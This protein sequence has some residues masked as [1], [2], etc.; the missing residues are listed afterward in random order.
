MNK[1]MLGLIMW[2]LIPGAAAQ[3]YYGPG[4][5]GDALS[6]DQV[7]TIDVDYRFR[8]S[9]SSAPTSLLWYDEAQINSCPPPSGN[10]Y[11]CGTGGIM[12]ISIQTDDATTNHLASG[13][14]LCFGTDSSPLNPP[15]LRS[16]ALSSCP[17]LTAGTLYHIH[18]HNTAADPVNNFTSV[19]DE[20]VLDATIPRQPTIPDTDLAVFRGTTLQPKET[21]IFQLTYANGVKQGQGYMENWLANAPFISG[22]QTV[23]EQFTVSGG[24]KIVSSVSLRMKRD[25]SNTGTDPLTVTL[26]TGAGAL[27]EQGTI[28]ASTFPVGSRTGAGDHNAWGTY[29]FTTPRTLTNGQAYHLVLSAPSNTVFAMQSIRRG[30]SHG[31]VSPT[32]FGDG[33]GQY[34]TNGGSTW[35]GFDQPGGST[36][37]TNADMQFYFTIQ[38]GGTSSNPPVPPSGLTATVR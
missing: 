25:T 8:A 20:F 6:N 23:R 5:G 19:D 12:H 13:T 33:Y 1:R 30:P 36:N 38:T 15:A 37:N 16:Q 11:G 18:W 17:A 4:I 31:F 35:S 26:E 32:F 34:S 29:T 24:D 21:P 2:L 10:T 3:T 22:A 14:E 9:T 7:S 28:P 27:I